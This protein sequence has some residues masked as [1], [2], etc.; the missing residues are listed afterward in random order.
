MAASLNLPER[1]RGQIDD[2]AASPN[3]PLF[4]LH[5]SM[6]DCLFDEWLQRHS[7]A[8]YPVDPL[9]TQGHRKDDFVGSFFPLYTNGD[10]FKG[11]EVFGYFCR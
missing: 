5:H 8:E 11:A 6:M 2:L 4:I 9:V 10:M 1:M 7:D 3:D